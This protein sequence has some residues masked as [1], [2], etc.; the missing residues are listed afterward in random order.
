MIMIINASNTCQHHII[1]TSN[2]IMTY[3]HLLCSPLETPRV[4]VSLLAPET[5]VSCPTGDAGV[6]G[7]EATHGAQVAGREARLRD[8]SCQVSRHGSS[9]TIVS[10]VISLVC[11]HIHHLLLQQLSQILPE[12]LLVV[13]QCPGSSLWSPLLRTVVSSGVILE[14]AQSFLAHHQV[15]VR[16]V[17]VVI[18]L[19]SLQSLA[20]S[21]LPGGGI[22]HSPGVDIFD[23]GRAAFRHCNALLL[24]TVSISVLYITG[25]FSVYCQSI[26]ST[27]QITEK[28]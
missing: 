16:V 18:S 21:P 26:L 23:S 17:L 20:S 14:Q 3:N 15:G 6:L 8:L 24:P 2:I 19:K 7:G 10:T 28:S 25:L 5:T 22:Q 13:L 4:L 27:D 11:V 9:L 12:P 1:I